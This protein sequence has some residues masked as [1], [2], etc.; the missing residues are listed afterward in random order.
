METCTQGIPTS[1]ML[2]FCQIFISSFPSHSYLVLMDNT[3]VK[4]AAIPGQQ[5]CAHLMARRPLTTIAKISAKKKHPNLISIAFKIVGNPDSGCFP[6]PPRSK[7]LVFS[8]T[9]M[10]PEATEFTSVLTKQLLSG[11]AIA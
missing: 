6:E 10:I 9:Y 8:E 1:Q 5:G 4:L 7:I 3:I 2:H 11:Q